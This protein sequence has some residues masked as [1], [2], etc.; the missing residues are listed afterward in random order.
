MLLLENVKG[1]HADPNTIFHCLY[2]YY[3]LGIKKKQLSIIYSKHPSTIAQWISKFES[4]GNVERQSSDRA[5][6]KFDQ[7]QRDWLV[8][9]YKVQP[10]LRLKEAQ[11]LFLSQFNKTIS[12]SHVCTILHQAGLTYKVLEKRAIQLQLLDVL[13]FT[14]ELLDLPWILENLVFL[15]EVSFD[16]TNML[17]KYGYAIKGQR[18]VYRGYFGR[19]VRVSLLCFL[20]IEGILNAYQTEGTFTRLKFLDCCRRFALDRDSRVKQYPGRFSIW[21]MDGASIHLDK[22]LVLY[23]RSLGILPVFL[24]AYAPMY[25]PIEIVFGLIKDK[26]KAQNLTNSRKDLQFALCDVLNDYRRRDMRSLFKKCGYTAGGFDP[27]KALGTDLSNLGFG[28]Q[29]NDEA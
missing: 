13:R 18:L 1:R 9:L 2:G 26:L 7:N 15:D 8:N 17:R 29:R 20:G 24:P 16:N 28:L 25:N 14:Q 19:K 27:A 4:T 23:L 21:I 11:L 3:F 12:A 5:F 22:N 10:I 6:R